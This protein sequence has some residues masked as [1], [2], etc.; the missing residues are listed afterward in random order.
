MWNAAAVERDPKSLLAGARPRDGEVPL[1]S[2]APIDET[3]A[4]YAATGLTT[5]PHLMAY[6]R[7]DLTARGILSADALTRATHQSWVKTAGVV[8]VAN[9]PAPPRAF[10]SSR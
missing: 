2:M 7:R 8:I 3:L 1:A 10:C 6:L 4:D 5:G 9:V